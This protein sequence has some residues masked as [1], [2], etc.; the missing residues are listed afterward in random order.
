VAAKIIGNDF[1]HHFSDD[2]KGGGQEP[3][4]M[5]SLIKRSAAENRNGNLVIRQN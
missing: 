1:E 4:V 3:E 5:R 2:P